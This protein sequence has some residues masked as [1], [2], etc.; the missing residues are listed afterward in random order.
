MELDTRA[1]R[2]DSGKGWADHLG[3]VGP[4]RPGSG[5]RSDPAGADFPTGPTIGEPLPN[6]VRRDQWGNQ[7]DVH[8]HRGDRPLVMVFFRS[9]VW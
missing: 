1:T 6:I 3:F 8:A 4:Y 7:I 9:A 2:P 5:P